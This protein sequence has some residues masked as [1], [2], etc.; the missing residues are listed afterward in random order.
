MR[1]SI[2]CASNEGGSDRA[3][4]LLEN[5]RPA[6]EGPVKGFAVYPHPR[7]SP[8]SSPRESSATRSRSAMTSHGLSRSDNEIT[9]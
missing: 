1:R 5:L 3:F 7:I 6:G 2:V 8:I 9:A 4:A